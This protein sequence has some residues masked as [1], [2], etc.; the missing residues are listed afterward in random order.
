[1]R[2]LVAAA[3][4]FEAESLPDLEDGERDAFT[5]LGLFLQHVALVADIDRHDPGADAVTLMTLHS[6]K[7][8]E[9]PLVFIS[10]MEE[11]LFP[12]A[13][14]YDEEH[15]LEEERRLFYV[16]LTRARRKVYLTYARSRRRA[17][18]ISWTTSSS[19]L[20]VLWKDLR[21]KTTSGSGGAGWVAGPSRR[22][23]DVP[24]RHEA[25]FN[26]DRPSF[27]KGERVV[28]QTFGSGHHRRAL[29][30]RSRT[31][32]HRGLRR[33]GPKEACGSVRGA[34]EGLL[35]SWQALCRALLAVLAGQGR[36]FGKGRLFGRRRLAG[37]LRLAG[38]G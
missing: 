5:D 15:L 21:M 24:S 4:Q 16:G 1:M 38:S 33:G 17:G 34:G 32:G 12:L 25:D 28:H 2:E 30:V 6:S 11:G 29:G 31:E 18:E 37:T 14:A 19:F 10:G 9:F 13:R 36:L 3:K 23:E 20:E 8:L 7:G 27:T 26:Q 35:L 22:G